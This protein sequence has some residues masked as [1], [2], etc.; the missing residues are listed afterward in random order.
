VG[1]FGVARITQRPIV[2]T[3]WMTIFM[4]AFPLFIGGV[5]FASGLRQ[6]LVESLE[7]MHF[8]YHREKAR[9]P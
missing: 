8:R 6:A 5:S 3:V 9:G 4:L 7:V 2:L 1:R